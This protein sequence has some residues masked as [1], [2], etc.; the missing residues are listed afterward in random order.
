MVDDADQNAEPDWLRNLPIRSEEIGF[1]ADE[2]VTCANCGK[3]NAPNRAACLYCGAKREGFAEEDKLDVRELEDWEN[4]FNVVLRDAGGADIEKASDVIAEITSIEREFLEAAFDT[5]KNIPIMRAPSDEIAQRTSGKLDELGISTA[6]V[7]D[8]ELKTTTLPVRLRSIAFEDG[9][10]K[11][12]HFNLDEFHTIP[13]DKLILIVVGTIFEDRHESVERRQRK[14]SKMLNEMATSS[15]EPVIDIY[16]TTDP[17]GWRI[18]ASGFD[19][20]C[21]GAEKSLVVAENMK[22]LVARLAQAA[23]DA[24]VVDDYTWL[25]SLIEVAWPSDVRKDGKLVAMGKRDFS[26]VFTTS[27]AT[28]FT[29]YSRMQ[30]RLLYEEKV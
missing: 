11:L 20:S 27:N 21:L 30:W 6:I 19:F 9:Q 8:A 24:R 7:A 18:P 2:L 1:P 26:T 17:L 13:V 5:G 16:S 15:D 10:L 23:P 25:R 28:Q 4:G 3:Q 22:K 14:G 29:K 12:G